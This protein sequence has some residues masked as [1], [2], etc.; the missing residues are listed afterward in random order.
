MTLFM[1][2][3]RKQRFF[4]LACHLVKLVYAIFPTCYNN[5]RAYQLSYCL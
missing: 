1:I 2:S 5:N 3:D 4:A